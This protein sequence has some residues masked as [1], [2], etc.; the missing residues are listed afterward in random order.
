MARSNAI[1]PFLL[2]ALKL[3]LYWNLVRM[4]CSMNT[5]QLKGFTTR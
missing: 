3:P 2:P 1:Q 5:G 4:R